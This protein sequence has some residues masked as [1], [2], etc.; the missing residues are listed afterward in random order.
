MHTQKNVPLSMFFNTH[1]RL[2][3]KPPWLVDERH[4]DTALGVN[5]FCF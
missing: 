2:R 1:R 3:S 5:I 4:R